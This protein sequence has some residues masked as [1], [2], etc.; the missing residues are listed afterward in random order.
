MFRDRHSNLRRLFCYG[1]PLPT[2]LQRSLYSLCFGQPHC[3]GQALFG[4]SSLLPE[5][6]DRICPHCFPAKPWVSEPGPC[7]LQFQGTCAANSCSF[8]TLLPG[9]SCASFHHSS[10]QVVKQLK[11]ISAAYR[12]TNKQLPTK[13]SPYVTHILKSLKV[14]TG[15]KARQSPCTREKKVGTHQCIGEKRVMMHECLGR[16]TTGKDRGGVSGKGQTAGDGRQRLLTC[17]S[18]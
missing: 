17:L 13:H 7:M 12:M 8:H 3:F 5:F 10:V 11:G 6:H 18:C 14:S 9:N 1:G 16:M 4:Q 2:D 15:E